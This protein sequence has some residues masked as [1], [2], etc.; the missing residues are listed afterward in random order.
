M[1]PTNAGGFGDVG[2]AR[3]VFKENEIDPLIARMLGLNDILG[4]RVFCF[5]DALKR[6]AA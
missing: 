1:I 4:A 3:D 6:K 5:K 2:K